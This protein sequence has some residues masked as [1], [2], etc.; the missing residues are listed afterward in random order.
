MEIIVK[1]ENIQSSLNIVSKALK[2]SI[3]SIYDCILIDATENNIQLIC[4]DGKEI[5]IKTEL[6]GEIKEKGKALI[7]GDKILKI[8]RP[9]PE[10]G[11]INIK[12]KENK[13][14]I[15]K[16][17]QNI[18]QNIFIKDENLYP[19][20]Q[21]INKDVK[22]SIN[23]YKFKKLIE[24][25]L[26]SYDKN[27]N[28]DNII[29]K[30]IFFNIDN[31]KLIAKSMNG[32]IL[33]ITNELLVKKYDNKK[34]IIPGS[35]IE[36]LN[37]I[38]KGDVDKE[39]NIY[40][41]DKNV[42]FEFNNTIFTTTIISGSYIETDKILKTEYSTKVLINRSDFIESL[43]RSKTFTNDSDK[44]PVVLDIKEN[45]MNIDLSSSDGKSHEKINIKKTGK[46]LMIAFNTNYFL[47]ILNVIQD[48]EV[49]L[50]FS[51]SK[52]PVIIKDKQESY[53]YLL[54]AVNI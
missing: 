38:I 15:I 31:E 3:Q 10:N 1:K 30:G 18:E 4:M 27:Q 8:V 7:E 37:K 20:I 24:K 46:D 42:S 53:T 52:Q 51:G 43:N 19:N 28:S 34:V 22:I 49:A 29:L 41:K 47:D 32:Y 23:E 14:C 6:F 11:I 17:G 13:E 35:A 33:S 21:N 44:K 36:E 26:F 2:R 50:Y 45:E 54:T 5:V 25:T 9:M 48:E 39:I 16:C 12:T 40:I